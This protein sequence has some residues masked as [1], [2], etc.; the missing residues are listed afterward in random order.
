[1]VTIIKSRDGGFFSQGH[2]RIILNGV[3][4]LFIGALVHHSNQTADTNVAGS[5]KVNRE[6]EHQEQPAQNFVETASMPT[7]KGS[8]PPPCTSV[9]KAIIQKSIFDGQTISDATHCPTNDKWIADYIRQYPADE[10]FTAIYFGCNKGYDA[11]ATAQTVS[12]QTD[13]F[14]KESWK[15]AL[16]IDHNGVCDQANGESTVFADESLPRRDVEVHCIEA[17]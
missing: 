15:A 10:D 14:S 12:R 9:E 3:A 5:L 4:L 2:L 6:L 7:V 11:V 13:V 8:L 16:K 17:M 1:M